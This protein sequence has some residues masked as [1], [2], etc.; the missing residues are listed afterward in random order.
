MIESSYCISQ[1]FTERP[2]VVSADSISSTSTDFTPAFMCGLHSGQLINHEVR[3]PSD[4]TVPAKQRS[5]TQSIIRVNHNSVLCRHVHI[6]SSRRIYTCNFNYYTTSSL[7]STLV[8][9]HLTVAYLHLRNILT[10]YY[11]FHLTAFVQLSLF[12]LSVLCHVS[13]E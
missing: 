11:C 6:H 2:T 4:K 12:C 13:V 1:K 3:L 7:Q 10:G 9:A 5:P 8:V